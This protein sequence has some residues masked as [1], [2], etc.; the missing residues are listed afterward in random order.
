MR[1]CQGVLGK[2]LHKFFV[3]NVAK[4]SRTSQN[5]AKSALRARRRAEQLGVLCRGGGYLSCV[6]EFRDMDN[7]LVMFVQIKTGGV[8]REKLFFR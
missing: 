1:V 5:N 4:F 8:F 6:R 3:W 2:K 7:R